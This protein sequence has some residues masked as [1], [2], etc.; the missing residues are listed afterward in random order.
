MAIFVEGMK[1]SICNQ[2]IMHEEEKINLPP[3]ISNKN[4]SLF[5]FSDAVFHMHC[6]SNHVLAEKVKNRF[7]EFKMA[8]GQKVCLICNKKIE[9]PDE[10]LGLGFLA[11]NINSPLFRYN[12]KH[13]HNYCLSTWTKLPEF[14]Q[15]LKEL[16]VSGEWGGGGL[17]L[18][19]KYIE[20]IC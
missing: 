20:S 3:F 8:S 4:D 7:N 6:F 10:Y 18:L 15:H 17:E 16:H 9:N 12:Y 14:Y 19:I 2:L 11:D 5:M 1:C 13:F